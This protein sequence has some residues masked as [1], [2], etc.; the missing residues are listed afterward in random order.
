MVAFTLCSPTMEASC[1]IPLPTLLFK[2][3]SWAASQVWKFS[4]S[5][6]L[7]CILLE[8]ILK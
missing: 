8:N 2:V 1:N 7:K 6:F 5:F 3:R 4:R